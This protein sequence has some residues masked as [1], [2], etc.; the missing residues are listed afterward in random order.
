LH[1]AEFK[2]GFSPKSKTDIR[3]GENVKITFN[4]KTL[5]R[6]RKEQR[7]AEELNNLRLYRELSE[8]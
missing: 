3:K 6:L 1:Q 7:I 2:A 5:E 8:I 4:K